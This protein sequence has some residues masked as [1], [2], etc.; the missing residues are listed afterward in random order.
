MTRDLN[1]F[2]YV[3]YYLLLA[4]LEGFGVLMG[5]VMIPSDSK[6]AI[7]MGYSMARLVLMG[8]VLI[9]LL[10]LSGILMRVG[11][12]ALRIQ[13]VVG[14]VDRLLV[15]K[16]W[17]AGIFITSL[18]MALAGAASFL[19]PLQ[20]WGDDADLY[21]RFVPLIFWGLALSIQTL[22]V[23]AMWRGGKL[24]WRE[25]GKWKK[26]LRIAMITYGVFLASWGWIAWSRIGLE[27]DRGGWYFPGTPIL[28]TQ[29]GLAW[30]VAVIIILS[31]NMFERRLARY[32]SFSDK[33]FKFDLG[34]FVFLW[35]AACL[36]WS[37][38][39]MRKMSHFNQE[40]TPPNFESYPYADSAIYDT[41][42]QELL[43]G[44]GRSNQVV[45]RPL[46]TFFLALLHIA[47]RGRY[48]NLILL[49]AIILAVIPAMVFWIASGLGGRLAGIIAA[50]LIILREKNAIALTNVIEVS[51][52]KLILSDMPTMGLLLLFLLVFMEWIRK[53]ETRNYWS[54]MAGGLLGLLVLIRSQ[55]QLL[56]PLILLIIFLQYSQ[57]RNAVRGAS[58]FL[59]ALA[60]VLL[61]W[62]WRNYQVSGQMAVEN[63]RFYIR[64]LASAY[65]SSQESIQSLPGESA[66][67]YYERMKDQIIA[68]ILERP[69]EVAYF[70]ASHFIHNEIE[71]VIYLPMDIR[72]YDIR[73]YVKT[74][75][76][77]DVPLNDLSMGQVV[78]LALNLG[79]IALGLGSAI[80]RWKLLGYVPL[81]IHLGYSLTVV[82]IRLSGWRFILP[83]DWVS[84]LY[85]SIGL[86]QASRM[87]GLVSTSKDIFRQSEDNPE[88]AH[89]STIPE[90][91]RGILALLAVVIIGLSF[92]I[93][94]WVI[95][96]RY[97]DIKPAEL[98]REQISNGLLLEADE[99]I[100]SP[101]LSRFLD[102]QDGAV[103]LQGRALY[104]S[105][106]KA[107]EY[108]KNENHRS[109]V[110]SE[111][112]RLQFELIGPEERL[113]FLPLNDPPPAFPNAA[114]VI[115]VGCEV[116]GVIKALIVKVDQHRIALKSSSWP[117]LKCD[118][119][120]L[121]QSGSH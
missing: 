42:A 86:A 40:P 17:G 44:R 76:F 79:L 116:E 10:I 48:E 66:N 117:G 25:L 87:V 31:W 85:Y 11:S 99:I 36:I 24:H 88:Q 38:E 68:F 16:T 107:G 43:I 27:P 4:I 65:T 75:T 111:Y 51:H 90:M 7:F 59:L 93:M 112:D 89:G 69:Q 26:P 106:Y 52:S 19:V 53:P 98:I 3:K 115:V 60:V 91:K 97:P 61:P 100:D 82:P 28:I 54:I 2:L 96:S 118:A 32:S 8:T 81:L 9:I 22:I 64:H 21:E 55:T 47:G 104:P 121:G 39:P 14:A 34:L 110:I 67:A 84:L 13:A 20:R 120:T 95:P 41:A 45:L 35:L 63:P 101:E 119:N 74:S 50:I 1:K 29:V 102:N 62:M 83:V 46:Y 77:W 33:N 49:Q 30:I 23:L 58:L 70:Y 12:S 108:W 72:F 37:A 113:V 5:M 80:H 18:T 92:P 15:H 73:S 78:M 71:G 105:Y 6:N 94:E 56:L 109:R 114:D 103:I 57:K